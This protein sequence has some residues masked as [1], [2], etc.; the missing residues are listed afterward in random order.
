MIKQLYSW[1]L[2]YLWATRQQGSGLIHHLRRTALPLAPA[3]HQPPVLIIPGVYEPWTFMLPIVR[4]LHAAGHP[5]HA[6][7]T[8]GYNT[9]RIPAAAAHVAAYLEQ[10]NL[11]DVIIV[12]HS[13]GGLIGKYALDH[14]DPG[15]RIRHLIA[16]ATPFSG[17]PYARLFINRAVRDFAPTNAVIRE[18]QATTTN[19]HRITSIY[20]VFDPHIPGRSALAGATNI[21]LPVMG[22]FR[23][24][25]DPL[26]IKT[27]LAHTPRHEDRPTKSS[28]NLSS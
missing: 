6:L 9:A 11:R 12:A 15:H 10:A 28:G 7:D 21:E 24:L 22:H 5:I 26:V 17:S 1:T 4:A 16:V 19:N 18:L 8:L 25:A 20:G 27:V 2:D 23:I 14:H 13:K 3:G